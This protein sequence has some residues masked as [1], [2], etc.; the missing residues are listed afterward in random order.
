V[1]VAVTN[2]PK[3]QRRVLADV[4]GRSTGGVWVLGGGQA[5]TGIQV[6]F[7]R[8]TYDPDAPAPVVAKP[9]AVKV[10]SKATKGGRVSL[11]LACPTT[12]RCKG[13]VAVTAKHGKRSVTVARRLTYSVKG[14]GH[15]TVHV[16]LNA[17]GRRLLARGRRSLGVTFT[18]APAG[19]TSRKTAIHATIHAR[20]THR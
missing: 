19:P 6:Q 13:T 5:L 17:T 8:A 20:S 12:A 10:A 18:V 9:V 11:R 15:S 2:D 16:T 14:K 1:W 4:P 7:P 3:D